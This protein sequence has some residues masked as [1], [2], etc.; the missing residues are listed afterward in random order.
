MP[1]LAYAI[2]YSPAVIAPVTFS[3]VAPL[4]ER[5]APFLKL[6]PTGA[7]T[8]TVHSAVLP[9]SSITEIVVVPAE[10]ASTWPFSSTVATASSED[11]HAKPSLT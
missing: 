10:I 4:A 9:S 11:S 7:E 6:L 5:K 3:Q 1:P 2:K 8:L